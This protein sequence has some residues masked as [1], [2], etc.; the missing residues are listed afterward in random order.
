MSMGWDCL[1]TKATIGQIFNSSGDIYGA[2]EYGATIKWCWQGKTED[3][4]GKNQS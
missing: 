2:Y 4:R 3:L 1:W